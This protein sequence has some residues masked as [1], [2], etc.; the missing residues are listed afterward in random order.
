MQ[1]LG[2]FPGVASDR[3]D[4]EGLRDRDRV[5]RACRHDRRHE[6]D[7]RV[8]APDQCLRR[9]ARAQGRMGLRGRVA[10]S[11]RSGIRPGRLDAP[12][13]RDSPRE[14][15]AHQRRPLLR[16]PRPSRV[17]D[18]RVLERARGGRP[19]PRRGA[20]PH[21]LDG[22]REP[23]PA[24]GRGD[25]D[26]QE[27]LRRKGQLVRL[28]RELPRRPGRALLEDRPRAHPAP[29]L[30]PDLRGRRKDRRRGAPQRRGTGLPAE[31]AGRLLRGGGRPRDH[32]QA[33]DHQH[34]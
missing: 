10:G 1:L 32:A 31:P 18:A 2:P 6:P 14:R 4:H 26:L 9:S 17:L 7:Y 3:G 13:G 19:R 11:R 8:L 5:R 21:P 29:R 23:S 16:R 27:Q 28:P 34:P 22:G 25:R 15:R 20:D 30:S 24:T 12:G 33:T